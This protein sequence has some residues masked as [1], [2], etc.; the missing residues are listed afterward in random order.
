MWCILYMDGIMLFLFVLSMGIGCKK[1]SKIIDS[2]L[3]KKDK[4]IVPASVNS[5]LRLVEVLPSVVDVGVRTEATVMGV[6]FTEGSLLFIDD[7]VSAVENIVYQGESVLE[8]TIPALSKG[9]HHLRVE[10][11]NGDTHT[12]YGAIEADGMAGSELNVALPDQCRT[13]TVYFSSADSNLDDLARSELEENAQCF[14]NTYLYKIEGHCD[15]RGTTEYNLSLGQ[16]RAA[17]VSQYLQS[18]GVLSDRISL[19]S[20]GEERPAVSGTN[21]SA[22]SK[23]RRAVIIVQE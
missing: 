20:Y 15:E 11:P 17:I 6:G 7:Q 22:W 1:K 10:N 14:K 12:L 5:D 8:F 19:I 4:E 13:L 21:E 2:D 9:S 18:K 3:E 23:N 16:R